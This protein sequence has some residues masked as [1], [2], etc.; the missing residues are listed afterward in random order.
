MK[1]LQISLVFGVALLLASLCSCASTQDRGLSH[2]EN[3]DY[4]KHL[5]EV[6]A[7]QETCW[8]AWGSLLEDWKNSGGGLK[9]SMLATRAQIAN[10]DSTAFAKLVRDA[11]S[12]QNA[13][14]KNAAFGSWPVSDDAYRAVTYSINGEHLVPE[15]CEAP[16]WL[17][18]WFWDDLRFVEG[19]PLKV[20]RLSDMP[21]SIDGEDPHDTTNWIFYWLFVRFE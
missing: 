3:E 16:I 12:R 4:S 11:W 9:G 6:F 13:L 1:E 8:K 5:G 7:Q 14:S 18:G 15:E 2:D 21:L 10:D 20:R 17:D 19:D